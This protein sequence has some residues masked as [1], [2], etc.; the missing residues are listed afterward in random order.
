MKSISIL[1]GWPFSINFQTY[2]KYFLLERSKIVI[3]G[4]ILYKFKV[5]VISP[6]ITLNPH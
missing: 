3:T 4:F 2:Q 6:H 5:Y 1:F